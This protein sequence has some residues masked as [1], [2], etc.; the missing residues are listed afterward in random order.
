MNDNGYGYYG[1]G[2]G[3]N[4][5]GQG[6]G[7]GRG[8]RG[9]H[10]N[11]QRDYLGQRGHDRHDHRGS[12]SHSSASGLNNWWTFDTIRELS[13]L[14]S[15]GVLDRVQNEQR[16]F[17]KAFQYER[18]LDMRNMKFLI[19]ILHGLSC[20]STDSSLS[21]RF[22]SEV[23]D[24]CAAFM[25]KLKEY[26]QTSMK[27]HQLRPVIELGKFCITHIPQS[28]VFAFPQSELRDAMD[29]LPDCD[30]ALTKIFSE[31][32]TTFS[33]K[34]AEFIIRRKAEIATHAA[35]SDRAAAPDINP[36]DLEP[37]DD[38]RMIEILP[39]PGEIKNNQEKPFLRPNLTKGSYRSWDHYL[40]VQF[41]LLREDFMG[42]LREGIHN[43]L[44]G[45]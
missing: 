9:R 33:E 6:R 38:F 27:C 36:H 28:T 30:A 20:S 44:Q 11:T 3:Q 13:K 1:S 26:I 42:P 32:D 15:H 34:K 18:F 8:G 16:A 35:S 4:R 7:R 37:P 40:D 2:R 22:I 25:M 31:Y 21:A 45:K 23:F 24:N 12:A 5:R 29:S 10:Q 39:Q 19:G 43:Y 41:R 17:I 14:S